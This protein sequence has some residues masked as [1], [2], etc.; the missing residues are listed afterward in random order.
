MNLEN[1][2]LI[3]FVGTADPT[4]RKMDKSVSVFAMVYRGR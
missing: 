3:I 4:V 2:S 1:D